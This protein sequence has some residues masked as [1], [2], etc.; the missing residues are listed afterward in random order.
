[1]S[2]MMTRP[3]AHSKTGMYWL[4][5]VVPADLRERV[6]KR[7]LVRS[8]HTKNPK[9]ARRRAP[10]VLAQFDA[11]LTA[12]RVGSAPLT[13]K[14]VTALAGEWYRTAVAEWGDD[15][16]T[17]GDLD[18]YVSLLNDQ[19]DERED[20]DP[21][22]PAIVRLQPEDFRDATEVLKKHHYPTD[23]A[24]V[25]RVARAIF[26]MRF[27]FATELERRL[28]G[29]WT[30]DSTLDKL[31]RAVSRAAPEASPAVTFQGL[32]AAWA[33][34]RGLGG[35]ALYDRQRTAKLLAD[36]LKHDD[37]ARVTADDVVAWK[38]ARLGAGRSTK[39]VANDIGELRPIWKW[40][41]ANRKLTFAENPFSGLAPQ[42][43]KRPGA[44]VRGPYTEDE[45]RRLLE[46]ARAQRDAS[47]RWL[48][49]ALCFTGAR[50]GELTQAVREDVQRESS[51]G[52]WSLH[53][54]ADGPARTLKTVQSERK[55]PIHPAL[56][57]EGFLD[58]V[59]SL[60]AGSPLFPDF[61]LDQF[62]MRTGTATKTHGRWVRRTVGI[63]DKTKDPAH[64]WRHRFEDQARR[65]GVPQNVTDGLMGHLN[66]ANES[67]GYGR[68]FRFMP[69]ATAPWVATMASPLGR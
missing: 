26:W 55:V 10:T 11:I 38:E 61:P 59:K 5:K 7:E 4:R 2:L 8:L 33:A 16:G 43:K 69:D 62:G 30:P 13:L 34:E 63:T 49:W 46:A 24:S 52:P 44:R 21:T 53:I 40:G 31:P 27:K 9:E 47:L 18:V 29:D 57:A 15:P 65:A 35:K 22:V 17:F 51:D 25:A 45:A 66:A 19:V 12:A 56:A 42:T 41:R 60:P 1:M 58:Y 6:G 37:P 28:S 64:A 50:L 54:H 36:F 67:E 23:P 20:E 14:D 48:P 3:Y 32:V 39:T 68:G